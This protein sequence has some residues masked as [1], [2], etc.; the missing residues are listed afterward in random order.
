MRLNLKTDVGLK[1]PFER[2][3]P[4]AS[5]VG[6]NKW[7]VSVVYSG[8]YL[9]KPFPSRQRNLN[10]GNDMINQL[11]IEHRKERDAHGYS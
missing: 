11:K 4:G 5:A 8:E 7:R 9:Q 2:P 6:E 1:E 3:P 10:V